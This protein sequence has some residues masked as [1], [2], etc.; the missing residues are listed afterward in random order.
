MRP[1]VYL[2][3]LTSVLWTNPNITQ[4][5]TYTSNATVI[6]SIKNTIE[7]QT[8]STAISMMQKLPYSKLL[9]VDVS[10]LIDLFKSI[11]QSINLDSSISSC[12]VYMIKY[13]IFNAFSILMNQTE[14]ILLK[15]SS[16]PLA[17]K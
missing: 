9:G 7:N 5:C 13:N 14:F 8:N 3:C 17:N 12:K 6:D 4:N 11:V 10:N 1:I 2:Q 16:L 15:N